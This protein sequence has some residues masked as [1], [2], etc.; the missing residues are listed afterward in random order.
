MVDYF[1]KDGE[2]ALVT[3]DRR[4]TSS[5]TVCRQPCFSPST[6]WPSNGCRFHTATHKELQKRRSTFSFFLEKESLEQIKPLRTTTG[7]KSQSGGS[8]RPRSLFTVGSGSAVTVC[9]RQDIGYSSSRRSLL[10][11][12]KPL[13]RS[14]NRVYIL[15]KKKPNLYIFKKYIN[16]NESKKECPRQFLYLSG[17]GKKKKKLALCERDHVLSCSSRVGGALSGKSPFRVIGRPPTTRIV[18]TAHTQTVLSRQRKAPIA[19]FLPLSS[20]RMGQVKKMCAAVYV[21]NKSN[22]KKEKEEL[23][24]LP[25]RKKKHDRISLSL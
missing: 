20:S 22:P 3:F 16:W 14:T 10:Y 5:S 21:A 7:D 25:W 23:Y 13:T 6:I 11:S 4:N 15:V 1:R 24:R 19:D 2:K 18:S 17:V 8:Q 12:K 9:L